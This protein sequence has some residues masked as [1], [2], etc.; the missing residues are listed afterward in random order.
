M[1]VAGVDIGSGST[2]GVLLE[3]GARVIGRTSA[4]TGFDLP[5]AGAAALKSLLEAAGLERE[6]LAYVAATGY[7]RY[8]LAGQDMHITDITCNAR[9]G[10]H[11][12]PGTKCIVD[13]GSQSSRAASIDCR[14]RV[15]KFKVNDRCAAGAGR[16]LERVAKYLELKV[17]ELG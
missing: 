17:E 8:H 10:A 1:I 6:Q 14:G 15:T 9:A 7:G 4:L 16:F 12:F 13:I 2:K 3:D 5:A 11:L